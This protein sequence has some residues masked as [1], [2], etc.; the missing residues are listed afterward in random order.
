MQMLVG[1]QI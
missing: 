1:Q